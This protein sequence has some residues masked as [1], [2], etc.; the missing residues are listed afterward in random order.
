[1]IMK[2]IWVEI[3]LIIAIIVVP[4][5]Y[6]VKLIYGRQWLA[7]E[8]RLIESWGINPVVYDMIKIV[9]LI[10]FAGYFFIRRIRKR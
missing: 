8:Y 1:M 3:L 7:W 10:G 4:V 6:I 5:T 9:I 2:G